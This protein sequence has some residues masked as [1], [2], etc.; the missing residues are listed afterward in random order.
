MTDIYLT[1]LELLH[2]S[3]VTK[4]CKC[5]NKI[6]KNNIKHKRWAEK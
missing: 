4:I 5:Y 3:F 1:S 2:F 6:P